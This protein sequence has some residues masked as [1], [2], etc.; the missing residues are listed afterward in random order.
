MNVRVVSLVSAVLFYAVTLLQ[1]RQTE[2]RSTSFVKLIEPPCWKVVKEDKEKFGDNFPEDFT[3]PDCDK[4]G[5]F[6]PL[7]CHPMMGCYCV[8]KFTGKHTSEYFTGLNIPNCDQSSPT[9]SSQ[10]TN[11]LPTTGT[12]FSTSQ[13]TIKRTTQSITP[14]PPCWKQARKDKERFGNNFPED[15][16]S[17]S[18]DKDG[19][20]KLLQCRPLMG[21]YCVDKYTGTRED[22]VVANCGLLNRGIKSLPTERTSPTSEIT[23]SISTATQL[24]SPSTTDTTQVIE[25]PCWKVVKEDKEKFGDNFPEDFVSPDC[26]KNGYFQPLQCHPMMGCYCVDKF[27]GK[28]TSEYFTGLNIPNCDQSS[29]TVSSQVSQPTIKS[30]TQS[31]TPEPPCSKQARKDK[32][33]F[34]NDF[35]EDFAS[36]SCDKDG[37][38]KLLQCRPL[39]GCYCVDKYTG[40]PTSKASQEGL[41]LSDCQKLP[42]TVSNQET[43]SLLTGRLPTSQSTTQRSLPVTAH[44]TAPEPPCLKKVKEYKEMFGSN[45][46]AD[47]VYPDCDEVGYFKLLQCAPLMGCRCVDKYTGKP[48]SKSSQEGLLLDCQKLVVTVSN[49]GTESLPTRRL[50]TSQSTTERMIQR[51]TQLITPEPPCLKKVKEYKEMFGSN[52]PEDFV[53]PDCDEVGYFKIL[54]CAPLMGCQCVDKYTGKPTSKS[55]QE[56][57]LLADCQKLVV[58]VSNE[59]TESLPTRRL[60]TSQS[61][62]QRLSPITVHSTAPEPPCLK[63]VKEYKEMFGSNLPEDFVYPDCDEVGYFKLL[64]CAPLMGCQCVDKYTGKPTSKASQEGILV[65]CQK[66]VVTVSNQETESLPTRRLPTSQLT[67]QRLSPTTADSTTPEPPCLKKVKEYKEMFGS[68]IPEDFVYPDCDEVGYFKILQCAPLMGCQCVD[69]YTGKPTSKSSQEGLLSAD[70]QKLAATVSSRETESLPTRRMPTSQS[71]TQRLLPV[72]AHSTAPEPPCWKRV[73][74]SKRTFGGNFPADF[75]LPVCD[76]DGYFRPLQSNPMIGSFC[77]DKYTGKRTSR[78]YRGSALPSC[79]KS[80]LAVSSHKGINLLLTRRTRPTS[81]STTPKA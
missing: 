50:P 29:P 39:M 23:T 49:E 79:L 2:G 14:E 63:K 46:P 12:K 19:Y 31:I 59:G 9:V 38:F 71:T 67:T 30:T 54:Q 52:L 40:K 81:Q 34:G 80:L 43:E 25:P 58:T 62:T 17:L 56:G 18:C 77:V 74:K 11:P 26:D 66:L 37:Y 4:N 47:F 33:R 15:F 69:K 61:T 24:K 3:S 68:N 75:V 76:K 21:C 44:S 53:Y 10:V 41:F 64:Q 13:P 1:M 32:E 57:L 65:D 45:L 8:D 55:S 35:P 28:H 7:Q 78:F 27:T 36:L 72:T 6:Q 51:T 73:R 20:F 70:C 5:Y 22:P 16:S 42:V 60:P 48:I